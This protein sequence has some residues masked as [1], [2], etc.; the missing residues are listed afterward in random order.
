MQILN[1]ANYYITTLILNTFMLPQADSNSG[2]TNPD[3]FD[4]SPLENILWNWGAKI[5][6]V[7]VVIGAIV[8][9][10]SIVRSG[11]AAMHSE[12]EEE[13]ASFKKSLGWKITGLVILFASSGILFALQQIIQTARGS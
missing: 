6:G 7:I 5:L 3:N 1:Q 9:L 4:F 13:K 11:I 2:I 12:T 8:F 10:F